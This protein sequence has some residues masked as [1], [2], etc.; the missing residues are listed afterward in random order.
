MIL[1]HPVADSEFAQEG[2]L[3]KRRIL[4]VDDDNDQAEALALGLSRQGFQPLLASTVSTGLMIAQLHD[5]D[6]ILLDI[7]LPDGNGLELCEWLAD[8]PETAD[9][10]IILLSAMGGDEI[11]R[12]ARSAGSMYF[13]R[14]PY[15]PNALLTL[16]D[17]ALEKANS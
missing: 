15:D 9:I 14:K 11:V 6:L 16:V 12:Q 10:P 5:P 7:R 4:I 13:V 1:S 3:E 8:S 2:H 17:D